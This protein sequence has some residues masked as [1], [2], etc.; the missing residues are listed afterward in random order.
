MQTRTLF[1]AI[2]LALLPAAALAQWP[3]C[4]PSCKSCGLYCNS[5]CAA[6]LTMSECDRCLY[7][8]RESSS[9]GFVQIGSGDTN[10]PDP[11]LCA[12]CQDSCYCR[13][14][15]KC[16]DNITFTNPPSSSHSAT[17]TP[18]SLR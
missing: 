16:Y 18:V 8:R 3:S 9:C 13:I 12:A 4:D 11:A 7:C 2:C 6:P 17:P 1:S 10:P 14:D 15:A 5:G